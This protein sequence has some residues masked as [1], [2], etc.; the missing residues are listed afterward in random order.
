MLRPTTHNYPV[1]GKKTL[2]VTVLYNSE[3]MLAPW[4]AGVRRLCEGSAYPIQA[5]V[6]DNASDDGT[7]EKLR[8]ML[9]PE[10]PIRLIAHHQNVGWGA[11][12]NIGLQT[13]DPVNLASFDAV[14]FLNPDVILPTEAHDA[15]RAAL[16]ED[17][18]VGG[19]I[20]QMVDDQG[21]IR[22]PA[23]PNFTATDSILG[24][25]GWRGR[26]S[27]R[28]QRAHSDGTIQDLHGGYAE[29][30]CVMIRQAALQQAGPF[31]ETFFM[32]FDDT[33]LTHRLVKAGY[34]IQYRPEAVATDLPGKG[35]RTRIDRA[36]NRLDRYVHYLASELPYYKKWHGRQIAI[37]LARYK[38]YIDLPMR[39]LIWRFRHGSKG[40]RKRCAS[41]VRAF[42]ANQKESI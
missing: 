40:L 27:S 41:I 20:P 21:T 7:V 4:L 8:G 11:G 33:D 32:Y 28:W 19:V 14:V 24:V 29:G 13:I 38:L 30:S 35:S 6:V 34:H 12:N 23:F 3:P 15:M 9:Q 25:F 42:L 2:L 16:L 18:Q 5:S 36:E 37:W 22:I 17:P 10:D 1:N 39:S 31:D 26:H